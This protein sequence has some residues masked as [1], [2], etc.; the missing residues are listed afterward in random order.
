MIEVREAFSGG[1]TLFSFPSSDFLG[2]YRRARFAKRPASPGTTKGRKPRRSVSTKNAKTGSNHSVHVLDDLHLT[3]PLESLRPRVRS[4]VEQERRR[5]ARDIHDVSGQYIVAALLRLATL[6]QRVD[7][8]DLLHQVADLR[9]ML[10]RLSEEL[11]EV[12]S[13]ARAGIPGSGSLIA[14]LADMIGQWESRIGIATA[15]R[16]EMGDGLNLSDVVSKAV[17]RIVQ[18]GLTNIAKHA[19]SA[20]HVLVY[21]RVGEE[22]LV[23]CIEDDGSGPSMTQRKDRYP[24]G[25]AGVAG[26]MARVGELGG[27]FAL[28]SRAGKGT[29]LL[30]MLPT[31]PSAAQSIGD[32]QR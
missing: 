28:R 2:Q 11:E 27:D 25:H 13:G 4:A 26:M 20:T 8:P 19:A 17:F 18:E 14:A 15:F 12:G 5:L 3:R 29:R 31:N 21:L 30:I 24:R 9:T 6:E 22:R 16:H 23:L 32:D 10:T 7:D 1:E